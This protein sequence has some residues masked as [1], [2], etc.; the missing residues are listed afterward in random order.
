MRKERVKNIIRFK[1]SE[2]IRERDEE[3]ALCRDR[4][5]CVCV[6]KRG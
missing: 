6:F 3:E 4:C 1:G 2:D 5:F